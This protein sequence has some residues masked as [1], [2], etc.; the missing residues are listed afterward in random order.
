MKNGNLKSMSVDD[1]WEL[2]ESVVA[3]LGQKMAAERTMLETRLRQLGVGAGNGGGNREKRAYPKVFPKYRNPK[4]H[5]ETWAGRG[6]QPRWLMAQ[7]RSGKKLTDFL[8]RQERD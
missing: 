5:T 6:K 3:E 7:L 1:L 2:H 4:N 8:I